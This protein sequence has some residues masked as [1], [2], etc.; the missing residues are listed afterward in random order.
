MS[1]IVKEMY[2]H[3]VS[4][5][6]DWKTERFGCRRP[7]NTRC[8][9]YLKSGDCP[10]RN[11]SKIRTRKN[12]KAV[13]A[14]RVFPIVGVGASA[15][16]LEAFTLLL[17]HLPANTGMA[18]VLVQH[19][20]PQHESAL[21]SILSRITKIPISE[22]LDNMR[23]EPNHIYV[24]PPNSNM[25]IVN[26]VLMLEPRVAD[27]TANYSIN[28]FLKSLALDQNSRAIGVI[29]SGSAT[30][31]TIGLE[32]IKEEGGITFAQDDS[33]KYESMPRSAIGTGCVDFVL[34]PEKIAAE[35][36]R[37][38][39]NP[40]VLNAYSQAVTNLNSSTEMK[41]AQST[42]SHSTSAVSSK[43]AETKSARHSEAMAEGIG[44]YTFFSD[45]SYQKLI[46]LLSH[47]SDVDFSLYKPSTIQR[48]MA[49]RVVL[50]K[51]E[52]FGSYVQFLRG[53][54]KELDSLYS[55][56]LINVT[57]FFR[58][59][60]VFETLKRSV[61]PQLH[62]KNLD[63]PVRV[64]VV[65]CSTGQE[66]YS[67]A[68]SFVEISENAGP[69]QKMQ[70]FATDIN[71]ESLEKARQGLYSRALVADISPKRLSRFFTEE[72]GGYRVSKTLREMC[73]FAKHNL[74]NDPPFS[75][76]DL[77]S[78][79][80]VLIY[81]DQS[82][83]QKALPIFHYALKPTGYL[84]LG[85]SESASQFTN[86]F[87]S[88]DKKLRIFIRKHG[89]TSARDLQYPLRNSGTI[90]PIAVFRKEESKTS[91][92]AELNAQREADRITIN[93]FAPPGVLINSEMIIL[94]FRGDTQNY[95]APPKGKADFDLLKMSRE[96]MM[97]PLR[98]SINKAAKEN[99]SIH[100]TVNLSRTIGSVTIEVIPLI[101]LKERCYLVLFKKARLKSWELDRSDSHSINE[102]RAHA[103]REN[104]D[105]PKNKRR[106]SIRIKELEREL[107]E[108]RDFAQ[109]VEERYETAH[110]DLQASGEEIQSANEELQSMNEELETSK[111][112]I[113]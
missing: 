10:L 12:A 66:A 91:A 55:D 80:N 90:K 108:V 63:D 74:I 93:L 4:G 71:E 58:N 92:P 102:G 73:V 2:A 39:S 62:Q 101:N 96:G 81:F 8:N 61:F 56:V 50:N 111:E 42:T 49:R 30:D 95:L 36:A 19:L 60:E 104:E 29:L 48:R 86:L 18:M 14:L 88:I 32:A 68:M 17:K 69:R 70:V 53:N 20:D 82:I 76:M 105:S 52:S 28:Y 24:I 112:E 57:N 100:R 41:I 46:Q 31:G 37:L 67:I 99:K 75:R 103:D 64:W 97:S 40:Y 110:Y 113:E 59:P 47:H 5:P 9:V 44:E 87:E 3:R 16:G 106:A 35:L 21:T 89:S 107:A 43:D 98:E 72:A 22:V 25:S 79:R 54:M 6:K 13:A 78:C 45:V 65:G 26:G 85:S 1:T 27:R 38:A 84:L 34:P 51:L 7:G 11:E 33:A 94:Q 109:S 77:I 15:G 83:H 23:V